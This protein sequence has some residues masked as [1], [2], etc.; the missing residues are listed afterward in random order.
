M[1]GNEQFFKVGLK[2]E[3]DLVVSVHRIQLT[4]ISIGYLSVQ[5]ICKLAFLFSERFCTVVSLNV[6]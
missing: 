4:D 2:R 5:H 6:L 1:I 3:H